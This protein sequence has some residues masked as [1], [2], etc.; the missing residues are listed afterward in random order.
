MAEERIRRKNLWSRLGNIKKQQE[1][2]R[3]AEKL[4]L[5]VD[6]GGGKGSHWAIRNRDYPINDIRSLIATV[7]ANLYKQAN[8]NVFKQ[9]LAAGL[10]EDDIWQALGML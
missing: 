1:W 8:Q 7:P 3:A 9:L 4:G 5:K 6:G 2:L 10:V